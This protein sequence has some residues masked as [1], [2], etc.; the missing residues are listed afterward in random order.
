VLFK[1]RTPSLAP[2]RRE[3]DS[4]RLVVGRLTLFGQQPTNQP[5]AFR[6]GTRTIFPNDRFAPSSRTPCAS[7]RGIT[8]S[9]IVLIFPLNSHRVISRKS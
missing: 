1:F 9:T 2:R 3:G 8:S 6:Q 5:R 7:A 4:V